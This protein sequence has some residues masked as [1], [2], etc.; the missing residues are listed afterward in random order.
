MSFLVSLL[1]YNVWTLSVCMLVSQFDVNQK[2]TFIARTT[3]FVILL[4]FT[5][6]LG[7]VEGILLGFVKKRGLVQWITARTFYFLCSVF[8]GIRFEIDDPNDYLGR[9]RPAVFLSNHQSMLDILM[10]GAT[11]PK[12]CSVTA[13]KAL[14]WYPFLGWFMAASK[15]VFIDRG[16][17]E[18]ALK[19]LQTAK[20]EV[21]RDKQSI[22]MFPEGTRSNALQ[23]ELLP[24][25]K[26]AFHFAVQAQI[27]IV[28][29]VVSNY[30]NIWSFKT[31][32]ASHGVIRVKVLTPI[33]TK[34]MTSENVDTLVQDVRTRMLDT[35]MELGYSKSDADKKKL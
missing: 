1:T 18:N 35:V 5:A 7:F 9:T 25:K 27:P 28:P 4:L 32:I 6:F 22:F 24:F 14:K 21:L 19:A 10:L 31:G 20:D 33:E 15:T 30:S 11:F 16:R 8:L 23:P 12:Y 13:K 34:G 3:I 29:W 17:R 2:V 26:G